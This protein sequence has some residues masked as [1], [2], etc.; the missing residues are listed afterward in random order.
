MPLDL[1]AEIL[2]YITGQD[3][4]HV[5]LFD[6]QLTN[7]TTL[8]F[9]TRPV[10]V[11]GTEYGSE[12]YRIIEDQLPEIR[13]TLGTVEQDALRI[14][15]QNYDRTVAQVFDEEYWRGAIGV[16][17]YYFDIPDYKLPVFYGEIEA[18][19]LTDESLEFTI[20]KPLHSSQRSF[21]RNVIQRTC[22]RVFGGPYGSGCP[23]G[24]TSPRTGRRIGKLAG[25]LNGG[26][27]SSTT[28]WTLDAGHT[29]QAGDEIK[30]D[31]EIVFVSDVSGNDLT[32][33]RGFKS[34]TAASHS[35]DAEILHTRCSKTIPDCKRFGMFL[36]DNEFR[37]DIASVNTGARQ[38]TVNHDGGAA[39][40]SWPT[41]YWLIG[42]ERMGW[43]DSASPPDPEFDEWEASR[44]PNMPVL[45][46]TV[47]ILSG[48]DIDIA[49]TIKHEF[50][51]AS[52][53]GNVVT[54]TNDDLSL[55]SLPSTVTASDFLAI[56]IMYFAGCPNL[57]ADDFFLTLPGTLGGS[58]SD[59]T[60]PGDTGDFGS[61][62]FDI[63]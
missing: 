58:T 28:T 60:E 16:V 37:Y 61:G 48:A 42:P 33:T 27:N 44:S 63:R 50:R 35:D 57:D 20:A 4:D 2:A 54:L 38:V 45:G 39:E 51:V 41:N 24:Q 62:I 17:Y 11:E 23:Y 32:V 19:S 52:N 56:Q 6:L 25:V 21:P 14:V 53:T 29:V 30:A 55:T 40:S 43:S 10:T 47:A 5:V 13:Y 59:P 8:R 3:T 46:Y 31:N 22:P 49:S 12:N 18:N 1:P 36:E 9:A 7:G 34:T 26:V 15:V